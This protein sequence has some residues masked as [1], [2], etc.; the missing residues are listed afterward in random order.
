[1]NPYKIYEIP[2][3]WVEVKIPY[4]DTA[5]GQEAF[6]DRYRWVRQ[7][8]TVNRFRVYMN[9]KQGQEINDCYYFEDPNL[10]MLFKLT[11]SL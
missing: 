9:E 10:A 4:H 5:A 2:E 6:H 11:W 1:V 7:R 3:H 8:T